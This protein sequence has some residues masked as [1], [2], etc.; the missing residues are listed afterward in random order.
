MDITVSELIDLLA[1]RLLAGNPQTRISG[2]ASL[3]EA[4]A[5]DLSFFSDSRYQRTLAN[6][7]ATAVLVPTQWTVFPKDVVCLEVAN[8]SV[9]FEKVV[10]NYGFQPEPFRPGIHAS[11]TVGDCKS[12]DLKKIRVCAGAVIEDGVQIGD[13]SEIGPGCYVG[14]G[15]KLGKDCRLFANSTVHEGCILG[16]RVYVH[17]SAVI[18]ADGFGY[19]FKDGRHR[20]VRQAGIVQLDDDVEIGAGTMVD[21][22]RFGRTWIGEGTKV[23]NLVQIAHNVVI[24]K[25]CIIISQ[26]GIAGSAIVGD[27]VVIAA[28]AGV[29]GHVEVGSQCIITG[30]AGV[31]TDLPAGL[32]RYTGFPA[33]PSMEE[34]RRMAAT[35]QLPKLMQRV[36]DLEKKLQDKD[37]NS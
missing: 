30:R 2:F 24:G 23:D 11:A 36:R 16:D 8:P 12:T 6:T 21:R 31:T 9:A 5:G 29:G 17:S 3:K 7:R 32:Q 14:R 1:A 4:R 18:G 28:Q 10:D 34:R 33:S 26:T 15:V 37:G 35:R 19:E 25:H 27:H 22:A 13:G 20:K